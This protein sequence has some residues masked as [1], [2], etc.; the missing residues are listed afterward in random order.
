V[1]N[2]LNFLRFFQGNAQVYI[3]TYNG[4]VYK[5]LNKI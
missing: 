4:N 3:I 1:Q 2:T 5:T